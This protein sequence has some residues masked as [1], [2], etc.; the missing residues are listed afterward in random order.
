MK[1]Y[2]AALRN[3]WILLLVSAALGA[4][5]TSWY[6]MRWLNEV[7]ARSSDILKAEEQI[8]KAKEVDARRTQE[9]S[10]QLAAAIALTKEEANARSIA[11]ARVPVTDACAT[12]PAMRALVDGLRLRADPKAYLDR[13]G[14]TR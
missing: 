13:S 5:G 11:I 7:V 3:P 4:S 14:G 12:S 6:R 9:L 10:D 2:W 1:L 8:R